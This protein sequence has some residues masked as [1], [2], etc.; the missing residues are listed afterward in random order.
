ME[1]SIKVVWALI[2]ALIVAIGIHKIKNLPSV[3]APK[4]AQNSEQQYLQN[5][6][7]AKPAEDCEQYY[8]KSLNALKRGE[9]DAGSGILAAASSESAIAYNLAYQSCLSR[10]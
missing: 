1:K 6:N 2:I 7:A 10:K 4:P 5:A 9:R 3:N 8:E